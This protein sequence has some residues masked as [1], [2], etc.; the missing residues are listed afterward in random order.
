MKTHNPY[1]PPSLLSYYRFHRI[2]QW[3]EDPQRQLQP[4]NTQRQLKLIAKLLNSK[5][6]LNTKKRAP[7]VGLEPTTLRLKV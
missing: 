6:T 5:E 2:K 1:Y 4:Y 7:D 3:G